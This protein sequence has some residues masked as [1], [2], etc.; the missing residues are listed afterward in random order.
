[1]SLHNERQLLKK[2]KAIEFATA[3]FVKN[4]KSGRLNNKQILHH[5]IENL[6][7]LVREYKSG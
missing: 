5:E 7:E 1:M 4:Y 6:A 2:E 3:A